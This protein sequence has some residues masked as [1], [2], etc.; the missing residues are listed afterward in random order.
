M[1]NKSYKD[2]IIETICQGETGQPVYFSMNQCLKLG[3]E[4][5]WAVVQ[6]IKTLKGDSSEENR[7]NLYN[8]VTFNRL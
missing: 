5:G 6:Y 7:A 8:T 2:Y 1:I 4:L 3:I